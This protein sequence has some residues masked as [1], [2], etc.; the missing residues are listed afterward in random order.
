[1]ATPG[2]PPAPAAFP[3][4]CPHCWLALDHEHMSPGLQL[5][6]RCRRSFE[7]VLFSPPERRVR[8]AE[9]AEA[10]PGGATACAVHKR[11]A[12]VGNCSRCGIFLCAV[13]KVEADRKVLCPPCFDRL[14]EEGGL[15]SVRARYRDYAGMAL[16]LAAL[17]V[18][19][20]PLGLAVGSAAVYYG[21][22]GFAQKQELGEGGGRGGI[23]VALAAGFV[24]AVVGLFFLLSLL[25]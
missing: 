8:V 24:E 14:S 3:V 6:P 12:A 13:C 4:A 20:W 9:V 18:F 23:Y 21:F 17:G 2:S 15:D 25:R 19:V 5:C 16:F 10:G 7:A 11:N 1:M 22:R